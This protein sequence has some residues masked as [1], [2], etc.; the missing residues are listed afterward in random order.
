MDTGAPEGPCVSLWGQS[1]ELIASS[2]GEGRWL[3]WA[4]QG[5]LLQASALPSGAELGCSCMVGPDHQAV[6]QT[7]VSDTQGG[8]CRGMKLLYELPFISCHSSLW[9]IISQYVSTS[10]TDSV[11]GLLVNNNHLVKCHLY[12]GA[13]EH[14]HAALLCR[15]AMHFG[16]L[17]IRKHT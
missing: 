2:V 7:N 4:A 13:A 8:H 16:N 17:G 3:E 12:Y 1:T 6:C 10:K 14:R 5:H 11:W 15:D 9:V